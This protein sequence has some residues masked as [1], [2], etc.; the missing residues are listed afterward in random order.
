MAAPS[1]PLDADGDG[2]EGAI[3]FELGADSLDF[4]TGLWRVTSYRA[5]QA[6]QPPTGGELAVLRLTMVA[7]G[8]A[9]I[10]PPLASLGA[11][12]WK[13]RSACL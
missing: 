13:P 3:E 8:R 12:G 10:I 11:C 7:V 1:D 6:P 5:D 4:D 9:I 2:P